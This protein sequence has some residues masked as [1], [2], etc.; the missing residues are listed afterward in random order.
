MPS[1][2]S[3]GIT[4][5]RVLYLISE[6]IACLGVR[7][8]FRP[9]LGFPIAIMMVMT[10]MLGLRNNARSSGPPN[11][12]QIS[13]TGSVLLAGAAALFCLGGLFAEALMPLLRYDRPALANHEWWRLASAHL[14]HFD[15][16]HGVLNAAALVLTAW[17]VGRR[18]AIAEWLLLA[19]GSLIAVDAGLYWLSPDIGWYVGASGLLHG[20]FAGGAL[21]LALRERDVMGGM[22][23]LLLAGKLAY[24]HLSG[25]TSLFMDGAGFTVV[26]EAHLYGAVGGLA[27]ALGVLAVRYR[28]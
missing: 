10:S 26:T 23:L 8:P 12:V 14:V 2:T 9:V 7:G 18:V 20:L 16:Q 3:R 11:G 4:K 13:R 24:E 19:C 1:E 27:T 28:R 5:Q 21:I 6:G 15:L 25:G 22:M 17:I